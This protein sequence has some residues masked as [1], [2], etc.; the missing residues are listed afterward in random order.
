MIA[1]EISY[2]CVFFL[3]ILSSPMKIALWHRTEKR[4]GGEEWDNKKWF[5]SS[6]MRRP[7]LPVSTSH[8]TFLSTGVL[9]HVTLL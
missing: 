4:E 8:L 6:E 1:C 3:N 9:M 7:N 5:W 2:Y